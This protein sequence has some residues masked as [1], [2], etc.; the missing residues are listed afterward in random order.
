MNLILNDMP[1]IY[2]D[3]NEKKHNGILLILEKVDFRAD[4]ITNKNG[5]IIW[6]KGA[7][8]QEYTI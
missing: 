6:L 4:E 1:E 8:N 5:G 7:N 3:I 2:H